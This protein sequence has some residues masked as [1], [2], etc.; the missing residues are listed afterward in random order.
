ME[1]RRIYLKKIEKEENTLIL[2]K[3]TSQRIFKVLRLKQGKLLEVF[4]NADNDFIAEVKSK[5]NNHAIIELKEKI[6]HNNP[7]ETV[8]LAQSILKSSR[9]DW[10]LEKIVEIGVAEI[11]PIISRYTVPLPGND[12]YLKK[13]R[14]WQEIVISGAEQSGK[15]IIP[16]IKKPKEFSVALVDLNREYDI[17][18]CC[19]EV[20]DAVNL[21]SSEFSNLLYKS[22]QIIYIGPEGGWSHEEIQQAQEYNVIFVKLGNYTLRAETTAIV[23][24]AII[25][26]LIKQF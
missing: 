23:A 15:T 3:E 8:C 21:N 20:T 22:K 25:K 4:W 6:I 10:L 2:D 19:N 11:Q 9:M 26:Y 1:L 16:D 18:F 24:L 13:I 7:A 5:K 14:R 12:A 17:I